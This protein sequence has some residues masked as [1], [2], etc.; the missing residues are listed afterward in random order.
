M[1]TLGDDIDLVLQSLA[2]ND[3]EASESSPSPK[4]AHIDPERLEQLRAEMR[5]LLGHVE[6]GINALPKLP[7]NQRKLLYRRIISE[8]VALDADS[9]RVFQLVRREVYK[10][11]WQ[12]LVDNPET[13]PDKLKRIILM[14]NLRYGT[15]YWEI[16]AGVSRMRQSM[17]LG[18]TI[19]EEPDI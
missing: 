7:A 11:R 15:P 2:E 16:E 5:E 4:T 12:Q 14:S 3:Y 8:L 17:D 13:V 19:L 10:E 1:S 18:V 6:R 9:W